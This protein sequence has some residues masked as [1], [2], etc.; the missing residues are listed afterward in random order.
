LHALDVVQIGVVDRVEQLR[1]RSAEGF[2]TSNS[3]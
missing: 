3:R 1:G 2:I